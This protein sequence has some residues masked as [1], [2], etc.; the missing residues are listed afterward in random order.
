M[1]SFYSLDYQRGD[2]PYSQHIPEWIRKGKTTLIQKNPQK[3]AITNSYK[4]IT[5]LP[6]MWNILTAQSMDEHKGCRGEKRTNDLLYTDQHILKNAK[7][8]RKNVAMAWFDYKRP[9]IRSCSI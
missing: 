3:E 1:Y 7:A 9:I 8:R 5:C 4:P 6:M 2:N